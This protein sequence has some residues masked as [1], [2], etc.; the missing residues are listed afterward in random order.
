MKTMVA[1]I[2]TK[3]ANIHLITEFLGNH[4]NIQRQDARDKKK[5][6]NQEAKFLINRLDCPESWF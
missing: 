2:N 4:R 6:K 3:Q 1:R 5:N